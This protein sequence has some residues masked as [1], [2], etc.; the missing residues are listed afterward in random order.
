MTFARTGS[1][2]LGNRVGSMVFRAT[3]FGALQGC[4][5]LGVAVGPG[6]GGVLASWTGRIVDV[7]YATL[8]S[9]SLPVEGGG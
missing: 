4:L 1:R 6:V 5:F 8:V 9:G 7:F 3:A 2:L